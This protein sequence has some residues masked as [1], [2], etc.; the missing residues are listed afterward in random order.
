[1]T[2]ERQNGTMALPQLY[3]KRI[4]TLVAATVLGF[5]GTATVAVTADAVGRA[6]DA[7]SAPVVERPAQGVVQVVNVVDQH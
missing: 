4:A 1:M 2:I 5:A 3:R 6:T 7:A